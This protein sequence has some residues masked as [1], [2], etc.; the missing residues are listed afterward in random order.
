MPND[1]NNNGHKQSNCTSSPYGG[2]RLLFP[3]LFA[4]MFLDKGNTDL[5]LVKFDIR[6][7]KAAQDVTN[8]CVKAGLVQHVPI[9]VIVIGIRLKQPAYI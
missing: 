1:K 8:P 2:V 7:D 9:D 4:D 6:G 5:E 3:R